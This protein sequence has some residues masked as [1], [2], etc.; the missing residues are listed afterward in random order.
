MDNLL[1]ICVP[2]KLLSSEYH[3]MPGVKF[4]ARLDLNPICP[5]VDGHYLTCLKKRGIEFWKQ[6]FRLTGTEG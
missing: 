5:L 3:Y 4:F 6:P 2:L 1:D